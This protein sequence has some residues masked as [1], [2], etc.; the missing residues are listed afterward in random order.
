[1][2]ITNKKKINEAMNI[3]NE[4]VKLKKERD[5]IDDLYY[6]YN[7]KPENEKILYYSVSYKIHNKIQDEILSLQ[8]QYF[9]LTWEIII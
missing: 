8:Y 4:I 3:L 1:M 6:K 7:D 2:L 5:K 9:K